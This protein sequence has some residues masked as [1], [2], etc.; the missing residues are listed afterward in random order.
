M[1]LFL[2][3]KMLATFTADLPRIAPS[4]SA[5]HHL[6]WLGSTFGINVFIPH[7]YTKGNAICTKPNNLH[8]YAPLSTETCT[9][10]SARASGRLLKYCRSALRRLTATPY[11]QNKGTPPTSGIPC[12]I[13]LYF[14]DQVKSF[15][16]RFTSGFPTGRADLAVLA[17]ELGRLQ[18]A[19]EFRSGATDRLFIDLKRFHNAVRVDQK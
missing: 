11:G 15:L 9:F 3:R 1:G 6:R 19:D 18:L 12:D 10:F 2:P 16:Q 14:A 4:T 17:G 5:T 7:A 8:S 13:L